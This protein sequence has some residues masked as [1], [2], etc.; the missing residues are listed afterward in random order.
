[1]RGCLITIAFLLGIAIAATW[2]IL[3]P[4]IGTLTQGALVA[5]GVDA[6]TTTVTVSADPPLR[7]LTLRADSI[8]IQATNLTYRGLR[9]TSADISLR[10]VALTERSFKTIDG[11]LKGVRFKLETGPE[12][13][14]AVIRLSGPASR[15]QATMTIPAV[16][17]EALAVASVEGAIGI[18]PRSVKLTGPDRVEVD[19]GGLAVAARLGLREDGALMLEAPGSSPIGSIAL[20]VPGQDLPFRIESFEIADGGLVIVATFLTNLS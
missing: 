16:D 7:L 17:A 6:D 20:V 1:M 4:A 19:V 11:T 3:P 5:A 2:F 8:R 9:S 10:D 15:I 12:L 14:V 18:T 13:G